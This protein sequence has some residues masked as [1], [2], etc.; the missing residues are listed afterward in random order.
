MCILLNDSIGDA[1]ADTMIPGVY[2]SILLACV[3]LYTVSLFALLFPLCVVIGTMYYVLFI[4]RPAAAA[5]NN[6]VGKMKKIENHDSVSS[7][8]YQRLNRAPYVRSIY[9]IRAMRSNLMVY[10]IRV[11][12]IIKYSVLHGVTSLSNQ[13][14][15]EFNAKKVAMEKKWG[16]M[17][18][19]IS[20][21]GTIFTESARGDR[22]MQSD[23]NSQSSG[24]PRSGKYSTNNRKRG[25]YSMR[26]GDYSTTSYSPKNGNKSPI[27]INNGTDGTDGSRNGNDD[28]VVPMLLFLNLFTSTSAV[29]PSDSSTT[30]GNDNNGSRDRGESPKNDNNSSKSDY[31]PPEN[32]STTPRNDGNRP[33][34]GNSSAKGS[35]LFSLKN[36][37]INPPAKISK[38][39]TNRSETYRPP[40]TADERRAADMRVRAV[41]LGQT[42]PVAQRRESCSR[43]WILY[44]ED[45]VSRIRRLLSPTHEDHKVNDFSLEVTLNSLY[46]EFKRALDFFYPDGF[47]LLPSE[48]ILSC[49]FFME[50]KESLSA[51]LKE[52]IRGKTFVQVRIVNFSLFQ[53]WFMEEYSRRIRSVVSARTRDHPVLDVNEEDYFPSFESI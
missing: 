11:F 13:K 5:H 29:T 35:A 30:S 27:K 28:P 16:D 36:Q 53:K 17:N 10:F 40:L 34:F 33:R 1:V 37:M 45:V 38:M 50:W 46:S 19:P 22:P 51:H 20:Y 8:S 39:M 15:I 2:S 4:Y 26:N 14:I 48:K 23:N 44:D 49:K 43:V 31:I 41:S 21:Q 52:I 12:R 47:Q 42:M 6:H 7:R 32:Y 25:D 9:S 24:C 18:L 3:N